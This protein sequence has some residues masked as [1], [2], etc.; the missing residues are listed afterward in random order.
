MILIEIFSLLNESVHGYQIIFE[1]GSAP[2]LRQ[3]QRNDLSKHSPEP[4]SVSA[5]HCWR[6]SHA[7]LTTSGVSNTL[8]ALLACSLTCKHQF[9]TDHTHH[10]PLQV[11]LESSLPQISNWVVLSCE[12]FWQQTYAQPSKSTATCRCC[13]GAC[14]WTGCLASYTKL[15]SRAQLSATG[16][17][18]SCRWRLK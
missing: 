10:L 7:L 3:W 4:H 2:S 18:P 16:L 6:F 11:L 5:T 14:G 9:H 17:R 8:L 12:G 1:S 15:H 13:F